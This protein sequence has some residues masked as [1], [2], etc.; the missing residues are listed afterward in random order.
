MCYTIGS[1]LGPT[2]GGILGSS[3]DYYFGAK[4][5]AIGSL[6]SV[7][8]TLFM[9]NPK[10]KKF[11]IVNNNNITNNGNNN[12]EKEAI[13]VR[14]DNEDKSQKNF[15]NLNNE[16]NIN[17]GSVEQ[18]QLKQQPIINN[19]S[20]TIL[21]T[22]FVIQTVWLFLLTKVI[23]SVANAMAASA[24]PLVLKDIYHLKEKSLGFTLSVMSAFN[25]VVN[26]LF[27]GPI[28]NWFGGNLLFLIEFCIFL[29][30]LL[31]VIQALIAM[32]FISIYMSFTFELYEYLI[33]SFLLSM[34]QYVLSTSIT[35][36]STTRVGDNAKGTLLG[37]EH[38]LFAAARIVAPQTG[39]FLLKKNG[40]PGVSGG[41]AIVFFLILMNWKLFSNSF[42][43]ENNN[44]NK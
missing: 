23:T 43:I 6:L 29:M 14:S 22:T 34:I 20:N 41:C 42:I 12:D 7:F 11:K 16:S 37:L 30:T 32:K 2:I 8:L 21:T 39:V 1:V 25:A 17:D 9:P 19:T 35:S 24:F 15:N 44:N 33:L 5:A 28:V 31:S 18:N 10:A 40:V 36:E 3:G 4:I 27:L 13:N 38:S 26:G